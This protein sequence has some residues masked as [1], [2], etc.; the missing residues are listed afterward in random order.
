ML[1]IVQ[2]KRQKAK[3]KRKGTKG[4]LATELH[5]LRHASDLMHSERTRRFRPS[6][7]LWFIVVT[8]PAG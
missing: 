8:D 6:R 4:E 1:N 5:R 2:G 7:C 3:G